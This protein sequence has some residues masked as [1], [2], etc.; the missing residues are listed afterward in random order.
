MRSTFLLQIWV[1]LLG[2]HH[3]LAFS[4]SQR[5]RHHLRLVCF[6][7]GSDDPQGDENSNREDEKLK[8]STKEDLDF[9]RSLKEAKASK[10]GADI[11]P[12]QLRQSAI[13]AEDDFLRAMKET[14]EEFQRAKQELGSDGAVDF[15]INRIQEEAERETIDDDNNIDVNYDLQ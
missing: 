11:P 9:Y 5:H 14:R 4:S 7:A 13:R 1:V 3:S 10:L 2:S 8:G 15:F 12:D 6:S